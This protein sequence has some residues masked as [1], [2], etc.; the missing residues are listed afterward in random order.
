MEPSKR[1]TSGGAWDRLPEEIASMITTKVAETS[2]APLEDLCS[3][4]LCNKATMRASSS[5][6]IANRFNL[7]HHY[8][9]TIW[10]D[11][12]TRATYLKASIGW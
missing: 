12:D 5:R 8:Q 9:S 6:D 7:E 10:G 3:L 11:G 4:R 1:V 2:V